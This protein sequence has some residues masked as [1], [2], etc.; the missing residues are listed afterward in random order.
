M[1]T[2]MQQPTSDS[3]AFSTE[4]PGPLAVPQI[5][6]SLKGIRMLALTSAAGP[7][8]DLHVLVPPHLNYDA[9]VDK[10]D[11]ELKRLHELDRAHEDDPSYAEYTDEDV[12]RYVGT[13]GCLVAETE[14]RVGPWD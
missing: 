6:H 9:I 14:K 10:L 1:E 11:K 2:T 12:C 13:L 3:P 4:K 7:N 8:L 5:V